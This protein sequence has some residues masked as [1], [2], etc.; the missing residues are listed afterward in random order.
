[1]T[2]NFTVVETQTEKKGVY[3]KIKETVSDV[4]AILDGKFDKLKPEDFLYIGTLTALDEKL[5]PNKHHAENP[6]PPTETKPSVPS[7]T[8]TS[9]SSIPA[10]TVSQPTPISPTGVPGT[11][12]PV[13]S[14][15]KP[16]DKP[17]L[18]NT[19][20]SQFPKPTTPNPTN[21][22]SS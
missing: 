6:P 12:A 20:V 21:S 13:Q 16:S 18:G 10:V 2:Q 1:M 19:S 11:Q 22:Q 7:G 9:A 4:R 5:N 14:E 3:V 15:A 17:F 8:P